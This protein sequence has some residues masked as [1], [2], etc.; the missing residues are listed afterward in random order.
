MDMVPQTA[1]DMEDGTVGYIAEAVKNFLTDL[2]RG[3]IAIDVPL[4]HNQNMDCP[5][6][7][8]SFRAVSKY[9]SISGS[10]IVLYA[11]SGNVEDILQVL[12]QLEI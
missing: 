6:L 4:N 8:S 2:F 11:L 10:G 5:V 12:Q 7:K 3:D 9:G 1:C